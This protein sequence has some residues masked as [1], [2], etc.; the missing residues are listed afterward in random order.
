M[1]NPVATQVMKTITTAT[2]EDLP[3]VFGALGVS[4]ENEECFIFCYMLEAKGPWQ[5]TK[6]E[7]A[8]GLNKHG[9]K[10]TSDVKGAVAKEKKKLIGDTEKFNDF[11]AYCF[12]FVKNSSS[13]NVVPT[14]EGINYIKVLMPICPGK[15]L[16]GKEDTFYD[17]I[18][19]KCKVITS[20][21]W[22]HIPKFVQKTK[23][24]AS[25]YDESV[26]WPTAIDD[27][28]DEIKK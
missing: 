25:N 26:F 20:D 18:T 27:F 8:Q 2:M 17:F 13:A 5:V 15:K 23:P 6:E 3:D 22:K 19:A 7:L 24:D 4:L 10:K 16:A 28:V 9:C 1:S 14:D 21:L 11:F 12:N